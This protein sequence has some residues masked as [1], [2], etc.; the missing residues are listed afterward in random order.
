MVRRALVLLCSAVVVAAPL[1]AQAPPPSDL[2]PQLNSWLAQARR[3]SPGNW[4]VVVADLSGQVIWQINGEKPMTPASTVKLLTTGFARTQVG[5][6]AR[7]ATRVVGNG[8]VDPSTGT[9]IGTWALELNGDPTLERPDRGGGGPTLSDLAGQL[10][11]IGIRRLVGPL[12]VTSAVGEPQ[13]T[14][15]SVWSDRDRGRLF[16]PPVGAI[17]LNENVAEFAV[18]PGSRIG[19]RA[20]VVGDAPRGVAS[21]ARVTATTTSGSRVRVY[22]SPQTNG[23]WV[24]SG[25]IGIHASVHRYGTVINDPT[26]ALDAAWKQATAAAGITWIE[27]PA[28]TGNDPS[29]GRMLA[30]VVSDPF[31]SIAHEINTRSVNIGAE[32]LLRWGGGPDHP[33]ALLMQHVRTITGLDSLHLVD[34]SGLSEQDRVAP[35]VF[36]NYL[37]RFPQTA[38]G[39]DFPLLLPTNGSGTLKSLARGLPE[40]GVVRAK[41]GTL[42]NV[43]TLVGYLGREDG[44]LLIAVMY[45]G[46]KS[47]NAKQAEWDLFRRLG[48]HGVVLPT[49]EIN[50]GGAD[51][52]GADESG[53]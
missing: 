38:N 25:H 15:P 19:A 36:I 1:G 32:L 26:A 14:Y 6:S 51:G 30:E 20:V 53:Q 10:A 43:S 35:M 2:V 44:T 47:Y 48:A 33:A 49:D 50:G 52:A 29:D 8:H 18:A 45:D 17:T 42:P 23:H 34:G 31:D 22:V 27:A 4:A 28:V 41:T 16:A 21:L 37:A 12:R 3:T 40:P 7:R 39:K 11:A 24:I 13:A 46:R 9:W 5:G